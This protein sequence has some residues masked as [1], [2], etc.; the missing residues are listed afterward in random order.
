MIAHDRK[1]EGCGLETDCKFCKIRDRKIP[2][3]IVWK[4]DDLLA[5]L[6]ANPFNPGHTLLV[7]KKHVDDVFKLD[8]DL[9]TALFHAA[10]QLSRPLRLATNAERIG[11]A[12]EGFTIPHVHIHLV[13]VNNPSELNPARATKASEESLE[14]MCE[15]IKEHI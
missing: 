1:G 8:K 3:F 9:Y 7:T 14:R 4:D 6:D 2:A 13:P 10:R 15:R 11:I 12:V 5:F